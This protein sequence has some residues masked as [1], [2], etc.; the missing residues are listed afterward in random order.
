MYYYYLPIATLSTALRI[1]LYCADAELV[2]GSGGARLLQLREHR[3]EFAVRDELYVAPAEHIPAPCRTAT[4]AGSD[5]LHPVQIGAR[6]VVTQ[7]I[8]MPPLREGPQ[9]D[10][11]EDFRVGPGARVPGTVSLA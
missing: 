2:W 8:R 4:N 7:R 10:R 6:R 3:F 5:T 9:D 11:E 1:R